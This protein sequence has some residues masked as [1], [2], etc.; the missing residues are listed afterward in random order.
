MATQNLISA[1]LSP[2]VKANVMTK[3]TEVKTSLDFVISLL[4]EQKC[5]FVKAGNTM[6]PFVEKAYNAASTHPEILSSVFDKEEFF[7]DYLLSKELV[8]I[9]NLLKELTTSLDATLCAA[10]SD[11]M[12]GALEVYAS[13]QQNK[14]KVPGLDTVNAELKEFFRRPRK[15]VA[16]NN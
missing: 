15:V 7:K 5:E 6:L 10:S 11:A 1:I 8:P 9:F 13:V 14:D 4:P 2:E 12:V 16:T 3:L